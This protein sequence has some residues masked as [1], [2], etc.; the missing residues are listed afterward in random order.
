MLRIFI[1][2]QYLRTIIIAPIT[3]MGRDGYPTRV[4][5]LGVDVNGGVVLDQIRAI[6][7]TRLRKKIGELNSREIS[8]VKNVIKEMLVD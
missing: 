6:D 4:K 2:N 8:A 3:S 7:K 1:M 5:I